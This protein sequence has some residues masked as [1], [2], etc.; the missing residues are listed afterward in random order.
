MFTYLQAD[1]LID[2][3]DSAAH[4]HHARKGPKQRAAKV[5][6]AQS[7][8]A[9]HAARY[10]ARVLVS[11]GLFVWHGAA[12]VRRRSALYPQTMAARRD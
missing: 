8:T 12:R 5:Y 6:E 11:G 9:R 10:V 7:P 1:T 2:R 3:G 4:R